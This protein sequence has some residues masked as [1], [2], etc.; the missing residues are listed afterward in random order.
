ML[1]IVT[2]A[3]LPAAAGASRTKVSAEDAAWTEYQAGLERFMAGHDREARAQWRHLQH[4]QPALAQGFGT[5]VSELLAD[6]GRRLAAR[7]R[8]PAPTAPPDDFESWPPERRVSWL[9]EQLDEIAV[10]QDGSPGGVPLW[11]DW[12]V[13]R[14]IGEGDAAVPALLDAVEHDGRFTRVRP[15]LA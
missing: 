13:Q 15:L 9:V 4:A 10:P 1:A 6:V 5:P 14:L 11:Q 8:R 2:F 3:C 12:R 7:G